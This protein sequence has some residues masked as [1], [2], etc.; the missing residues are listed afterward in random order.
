M[1][2]P[3]QACCGCYEA[4]DKHRT[5]TTKLCLWMAA[6]AALKGLASALVLA[7][8]IEM[9]SAAWASVGAAVEFG[10][11]EGPARRDSETETAR[12]TCHAKHN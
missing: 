10:F 8:R 5:A 2:V 7:A 3:K 9:D 1:A 4:A 6:Q 12:G 11:S